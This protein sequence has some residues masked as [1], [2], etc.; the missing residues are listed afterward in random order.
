MGGDT[1]L[2]T[3]YAHGGADPHLTCFDLHS[4]HDGVA[5][6]ENAIG[7]DFQFAR[8]HLQHSSDWCDLPVIV[9]SQRARVRFT[10]NR[11]SEFV[12]FSFD[13]VFPVLNKS[14]EE[15]INDVCREYLHA[16]AVGHLLG[17]AL[18]LNKRSYVTVGGSDRD[19]RRA[20]LL[21]A[22][23]FHE[24]KQRHLT[25]PF[26]NKAQ[27]LPQCMRN[28]FVLTS[29]E[30]GGYLQQLLHNVVHL[31]HTEANLFIDGNFSAHS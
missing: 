2:A 31:K 21:F 7:E 30:P 5:R 15:M 29:I 22:R 11:L 4:H 13:Q 12:L 26:L 20:P 25:F 24:I 16:E 27:R 28:I 18:H 8:E 23:V 17:F 6:L 1:H 14:V 19:N 3:G 10:Y 9:T